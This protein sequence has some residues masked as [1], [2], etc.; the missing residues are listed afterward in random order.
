MSDYAR[1][2]LGRVFELLTTDADITTLFEP[3]LVWVNVTDE[4]PPVQEG[5]NA[6]TDGD[7]WFFSE[8]VAPRQTVEELLANRDSLLAY[9]AIRIAPFQDAVDL[10]DASTEEKEALKKWKQ[11]RVALNRI[12]DQPGFPES[13]IWPVEPVYL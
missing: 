4:T 9:A 11:Y 13:I 12:Q 6:A 7:K 1:I 2:H 10:D 3:S 8:Y 5:W